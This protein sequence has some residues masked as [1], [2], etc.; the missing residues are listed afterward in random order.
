MKIDSNSYNSVQPVYV[1]SYEIQRTSAA[2]WRVGTLTMGLSLLIVGIVILI[3]HVY[4]Y[5]SWAAAKAWWPIY[6]ILLGIEI[7]A[8]SIFRR[9]M[10]IQYDV[11]SIFLI[12]VL[13]VSSQA[14][15][16]LLGH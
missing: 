12:S 9:N 16:F 8:H 3:S 13:A 15:L 6:F 10:R 5:S 7:L 2:K 14:Y 4:G 1:R 11:M